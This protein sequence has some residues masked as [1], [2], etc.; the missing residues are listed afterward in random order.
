LHS[1]LDRS[2]Q[3]FAGE[4]AFANSEEKEECHNDEVTGRKRRFGRSWLVPN[5]RCRPGGVYRECDLGFWGRVCVPICFV[6]M[7]DGQVKFLGPVGTAGVGVA[8]HNGC[9][10]HVTDGFLDLLGP[11]LLLSSVVSSSSPGGK[12]QE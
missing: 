6:Q 2:G 8:G 12:G 10:R 3:S 1:K 9:L 4:S 7:I 5:R 11:N